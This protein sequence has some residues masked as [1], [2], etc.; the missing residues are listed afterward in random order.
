MLTNRAKE[1]QGFGATYKKT[2]RDRAGA[3]ISMGGFGEALARYENHVELD[4]VR[5]DKWGIPVLRFSYGFGENDKEMC[6][7]M[8]NAAKEMFEWPGIEIVNGE[9]K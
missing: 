1:T 2:V 8:A 7:D 9:R 3:Y 6:D 4:P 5:K